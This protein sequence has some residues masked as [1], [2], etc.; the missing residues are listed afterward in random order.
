[1]CHKGMLTDEC[2]RLEGTARG[3]A[4]GRWKTV[5]EIEIHQKLIHVQIECR[6]LFNPNLRKSKTF[7]AA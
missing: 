5:V 3:A 7:I 6:F 2:S 4:R 1:M